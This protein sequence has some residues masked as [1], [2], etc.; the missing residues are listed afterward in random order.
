T[1]RDAPAGWRLRDRLLFAASNPGELDEVREIAGVSANGR[2]FSLSRPLRFDHNSPSEAQAAVP[3]GNITRNI[4]FRSMQADRLADRA[5]IMIA[6]RESADIRGAAFQRLG[7]TSALKA[8]S[9]PGRNA[10]GEEVA[11]DNPIGRYAVHF[12]IVSGLSRDDP[13]SR[14]AGNVIVDSPKYGLVN[15][16]AYVIAEDNVTLGVKGA[17]FFAENGSEI[18]AFRRNLAVYSRGSSDTIRAR[19]DGVADFGHGGHGFWSQS[20]ALTIEDNYA[21][22]HSGAAYVVFAAAT[23]MA[24]GRQ[25]VTFRGESRIQ[26][27]LAANLAPE[28]RAKLT[29]EFA[30][31]TVVPFHFA[32]NVGANSDRGLEVWNTNIIAEHDLPSTIEDSVFWG[33]GSAGIAM[34]YAVNTIVRDT[35][36]IGADPVGCEGTCEGSIGVTTEGRTRNLDME[37]VRIAKFST[38]VRLPMRGLTR[39]A[40]SS[41][42]NKYNLLYYKTQQPGR[43]TVLD[44]NTF[45][46]H[47]AGGE[48]YH[49]L[50]GPL[51]HGDVSML[52]ETAPIIVNDPRFPGQSLFLEQQLPDAIPLADTDIPEFK[53]K[54]ARQIYEEYGLAV[55]G[56]LAPDKVATAPGIG[57]HFGVGGRSAEMLDE[58]EMRE[59]LDAAA[60]AGTG[61]LS[62]SSDHEEGYGVDC[63][64]IHR[65]VQAEDGE[66]GGW[67]V[68]T[69]RDGSGAP[70][71]RLTY[72]DAAPPAFKI[73]PRISLRIHPDDV[74]YGYVIEGRL[75]DE[76]EE[77][78]VRKVFENFVIADDGDLHLDFE[79]PDRSG[80]LFRQAFT[81]AVDPAAPKRGPDILRDLRASIVASGEPGQP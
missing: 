62:Y 64:N 6:T 37:N 2:T 61:D 7:R 1:F 41:F 28:V 73:D 26:N 67:K 56:V 47:R 69:V 66:T 78:T 27:L 36:L 24:D 16:G 34:T 46:A 63:C 39:I 65:V 22:H 15:H 55:G 53:G 79:Y 80:N 59:R 20:P 68:E 14:F 42:D 3:V 72:I 18:G 29:G 57:A 70:R 52:F 11:G 40:N 77:Q 21:F 71:S 60:Q 49:F 74:K 12:H 10:D 58:K 23:E 5:H 4:V 44:G 17:H 75:I 13:P 19:E 38:G 51:F 81:V 33:L 31:P 25:N 43:K 76:N 35:T 30:P 48:D 9:L 32:R 50:G 8:H 45:A 54:T